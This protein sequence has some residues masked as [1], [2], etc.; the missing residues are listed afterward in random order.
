MLAA[1]ERGEDIHARTAAEI[2]AAGGPVTPEMRRRAK[3]INFG[4]IYGMSA[5]GLSRALDIDHRQAQ[6]YID[7]YFSRYPGV[8]RYMQATIEAARQNGFVATLFGRRLPTPDVKASNFPVRQAA[9][10]EAINAP[11]QGTA[12]D[13]IKLAMIRIERAM[14][15][16]GLRSKM[17]MQVHDELVFEV[18]PE[19]LEAVRE[20]AVREMEGAF[21]MRV[22]LK[23]DVN[24]GKNWAEAH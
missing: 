9:E 7:L 19:E 17:I 22:P 6:E 15:A 10:R 3:A 4:I 14:A 5:H 13:I 21:P 24:H 23:V 8:Q 12:A 16:A 2:F 1:F 18:E 20:L 11:I